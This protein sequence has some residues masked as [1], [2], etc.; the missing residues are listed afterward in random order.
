MN[1]RKIVEVIEFT[2]P[3]HKPRTE[4]SRHLQRKNGKR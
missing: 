1:E 2:D 4:R 3:L